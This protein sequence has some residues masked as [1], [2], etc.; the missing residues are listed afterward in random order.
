MTS[1]IEKLATQGHL[2][3]LHDYR[4]GHCASIVPSGTVVANPLDGIVEGG[5]GHFRTG[6]G[7]NTVWDQ[8]ATPT[9][10]GWIKTLNSSIGLIPSGLGCCILA[11]YKLFAADVAAG[12]AKASQIFGAMNNNGALSGWAIRRD[13]DNLY[14]VDCNGVLFSHHDYALPARYNEIETVGITYDGGVIGNN[15]HIHVYA[16]VPSSDDGNIDQL[17]Y[18]VG[19]IPASAG[20]TTA[21]SG[22]PVQ[23]ILR[24]VAFLKDPVDDATLEA[25][26]DEIEA[27]TYPT[28]MSHGTDS[29]IIPERQLQFATGFGVDKSIVDETSLYH[30][31]V[32]NSRFFTDI[33]SSS[34]F[35]VDTD[36]P[37]LD[38]VSQQSIVK[39]LL[40]VDEDGE[41]TTHLYNPIQ[42]WKATEN[43]AAY[44][45]WDFCYKFEPPDGAHTLPRI[46]LTTNALGQAYFVTVTAAGMLQLKMTPGGATIIQGGPGDI[47]GTWVRIRVTRTQVGS[48][49]MFLNET[50]T[51]NGWREIGSPAVENTYT[52]SIAVLLRMR[53]GEQFSLGNAAGEFCFFKWNG[54]VDPLP[55]IPV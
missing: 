45:T 55:I 34:T 23:G 3:L 16:P 2:T 48:W 33:N 47:T 40:A 41:V 49:R 29:H 20:S 46:Y 25:L 43:E 50:M 5:R 39:T 24:W 27:Q 7:F 15:S 31:E 42:Y 9:S 12:Y 22:N 52:D 18:N 14:F 4:A 1:L 36:R 21:A 35:R 8:A 30:R 32:S 44:G 37:A 19:A 28:E 11:S 53:A 17:P 26:K 13:A 10:A 38:F 6:I 54:V 51:L